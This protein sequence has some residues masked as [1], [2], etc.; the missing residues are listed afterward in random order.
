ML[1]SVKGF[2]ELFLCGC[3][4]IKQGC[5]FELGRIYG[6]CVFCPRFLK[7]KQNYVLI[8]DKCLKKKKVSNENLLRLVL[9]CLVQYIC[10][11]SV[12]N[13]RSS[14]QAGCLFQARLCSQQTWWL[15]FLALL[16]ASSMILS[17]L[18]SFSSALC[19]VG[20]G[21]LVHP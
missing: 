15:P 14:K 6:L 13:W 3:I 21:M 2:Q 19:T 16:Q 12:Q 5:I 10:C 8:G 9:S 18:C 1:L 7:R 4:I 11:G 20:E 17:E